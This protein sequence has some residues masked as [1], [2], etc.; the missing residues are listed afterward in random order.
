MRGL[1]DER[2]QNSV[3]VVCVLVSERGCESAPGCRG[4]GMSPQ[5]VSRRVGRG[6][7]GKGCIFVVCVCVHVSCVCAHVCVPVPVS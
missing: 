3:D 4:Q 2:E 6:L 1:A 7:E 5:E